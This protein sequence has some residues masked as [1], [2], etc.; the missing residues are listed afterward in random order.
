MPSDQIV[1]G[2]I[3]L[4]TLLQHVGDSM[5]SFRTKRNLEIRLSAGTLTSGYCELGGDLDPVSLSD[6]LNAT[7]LAL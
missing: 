2:W 6:A 4:L 7:M 1:S 5:E 3:N